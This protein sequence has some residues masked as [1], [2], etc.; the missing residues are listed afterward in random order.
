MVTWHCLCRRASLNS[1]INL[2][3]CVWRLAGIWLGLTAGV[4]WLVC[5]LALALFRTAEGLQ[6]HALTHLRK[7]HAERWITAANCLST[8]YWSLLQRVTPLHQTR[9]TMWALVQAKTFLMWFF[10]FSAL[11]WILC[12]F[13]SSREQRKK[14]RLNKLLIQHFLIFDYQT[15]GCGYMNDQ[16]VEKFAVTFTKK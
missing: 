3:P 14:N 2:G 13:F 6:L 9:R 12:C 10:F 7:G 1:F 16:D 8:T 15:L 4:G 5:D 11:K